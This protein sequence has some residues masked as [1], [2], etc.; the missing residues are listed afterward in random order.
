MFAFSFASAARSGRPIHGATKLAAA[1]CRKNR[2][3]DW[4][5]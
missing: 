1:T 4:D 5:D 2:R 3:R